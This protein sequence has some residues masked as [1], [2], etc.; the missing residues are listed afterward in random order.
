MT[1]RIAVGDI[2]IDVIIKNIKNVHLSV[3]PPSGRV[4]VSAPR[5]MQLESI[6][7]FVI[8]KLDWIKRHRSRIAVQ[9]RETPREFLERESHYV[10][11]KR[12]LLRI[13]EQE[14]AP[15]VELD[16]QRMVLTVRPGAD[17]EK[18]RA[19]VEQ[20]RREQVKEAGRQLIAKWEP[21]MGV[22]VSRIHVQRM[23]TKWGSCN[24]KLKAIRLNT[25]LA[26]KPP[27]LMEYI[28]VHEMAH[29]LEPKHNGRFTALMDQFIPNWK[30]H[31]DQLNQLPVGHEQWGKEHWQDAGNGGTD[32]Q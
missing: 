25:E 10:W 14:Q 19:V 15:S 31:R 27:E 21:I 17:S 4:R 3:H 32:Q 9:A 1:R 7:V 30:H 11:G 24:T 16:H 13:V 6:R 5:H 26:K 8:S 12:Y 28:V 22:Q 29:L 2:S 18:K 20:W 23:K